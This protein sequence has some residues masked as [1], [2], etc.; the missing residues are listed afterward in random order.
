MKTKFIQD[1][2][3]NISELTS[4]I[5]LKKIDK[6][7]IGLKKLKQRKGRLFILGIGG[8]ASNASH[9]VN[10]LR[11]LCE[12]E[13]YAPTDNVGELTARTND[14]G[15]E[16]I[17]SNWLRVSRLSNKDVILIFSV[18]GGN[19]KKNVSVNLI[20]AIKLAKKVKADIFSIVGKMDGYA[21]EQS[22]VSVCVPFIRK[23]LITPYSEAFQ[24]V[25]WHCLV[26]DPRLQK[27]K[28]KW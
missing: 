4:N 20:N 26:S 17:F 11:K 19:I 15:F 9:A 13:T 12:I 8:S 14:E 1:Y 3:S 16:T 7:I 23:D 24:A 28:T 5:D 22:N 6:I 21:Y 27:N 25:I 2:F 18:G 10:D